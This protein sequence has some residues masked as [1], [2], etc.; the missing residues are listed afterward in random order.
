MHTLTDNR[1]R[2]GTNVR[3]AFNKNGGSLGETGSV[4]YMFEKKGYILIEKVE[5]LDED[6]LMMD[7][8]ENGADDF[9]SEDEYIEIITSV[10]KFSNLRKILEDLKYIILEADIRFIPNIEKEL[11]E[12]EEEKF[13]NFIDKLEE[14]D[15]VQNVWHN[16]NM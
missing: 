10:D 5:G 12:E 1:N 8:L 15:D 14:N 3:V 11:T 6:Q 16:V 2:T 4:S 9:I 7:A 13:L